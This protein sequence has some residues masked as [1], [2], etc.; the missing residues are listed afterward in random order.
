M[1][2][3]RIVEAGNPGPHITH[4]FKSIGGLCQFNPFRR[5]TI[6]SQGLPFVCLSIAFSTVRQLLFPTGDCSFKES[7]QILKG[8]HISLL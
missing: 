3:P 8:K 2:K 1:Q 4:F 5:D 6:V 7:K